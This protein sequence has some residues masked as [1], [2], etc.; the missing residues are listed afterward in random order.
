MS[1]DLDDDEEDQTKDK[2]KDNNQKQSRA[3]PSFSTVMTIT[4]KPPK[5]FINTY[6]DSM[7]SKIS[8][9]YTPKEKCRSDTIIAQ[10]KLNTTEYEVQDKETVLLIKEFVYCVF[11]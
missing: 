6:C 11:I 10:Q 1:A 5:P 3:N 9:V 7:S 2:D 8:L 4:L